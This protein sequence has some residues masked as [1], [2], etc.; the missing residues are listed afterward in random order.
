M[1]SLLI[2][3]FLLAAFGS[4]LESSFAESRKELRN[5]ESGDK[6]AVQLHHSIYG[7]RI[8]PSLVVQLSW[9]PRVFL[10]KG[11]LSDQECDYLIYL[12]HTVKDKS[13]GN[14]Q[15]SEGV[16]AKQMLASGLL[17]NVEDDI[18]KRIEERIS[19]W[20]FLPKENSKPLQVMQY[21]PEEAGQSLHYFANNSK[22]EL[23]APLMATVVLYLSNVTQ[24]GEILFPESRDRSW[25]NCGKSTEILKPVKGN[26]ILFFSLHPSATPD[27]SSS[28]GRC[29]VLKGKLW[30]AVK[31]FYARSVGGEKIS[32]TSNYDECTDED[33]RCLSWASMGECERNPVFMI[34]SPDY[35]G[36]CRKSCNAC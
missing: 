11:F 18:V 5:K 2:T 4:S 29:P 25:S 6:I 36:T 28:H 14:G 3:V 30:S 15:H 17:L 33:D 19:V 21:G 31:F 7:N 35:Y 23:S 34:G 12:A 9:R 16:S 27:K 8:D 22:L 32:L 20:T 24:G 13:S 1:A 10:Y 26:A